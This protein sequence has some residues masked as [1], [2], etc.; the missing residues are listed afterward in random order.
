MTAIPSRPREVEHR[1]GVAVGEGESVVGDERVEIPVA[2]QRHHLG[3]DAGGEAD[4]LRQPLL[5]H[6][7]E[8][9]QRPVAG[10]RLLE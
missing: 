4:R 10:G 3:H 2:E 8:L 7:E 6:A 5:L 1:V 9:A